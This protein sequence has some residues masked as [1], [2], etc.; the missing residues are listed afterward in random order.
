[1]PY[2]GS[3]N[4]IAEWIIENLPRAETFVDLF[5]GG[6]AVTHAALLS[7][8]YKNFIANDIDDRL[9]EFF[10]DCCF[11]KYTV[12][13]HSEWVTRAEFNAKKETDAYIALVWSFGNNGIDYLYGADIEEMKHAYHN[14]VYYGDVDGLRQFGINL[15]PSDN[16]DIY[17]R[18]LDY[19]RQIKTQKPNIQL[20]DLQRNL[21]I[22]R[23]Q[24]LQSL[25]SLHSDYQNVETP[26]GAL[27][28]CDPPYSGTNCGKYK[29][30]DS[31][32]FYE[33]AR[34]Q[35]N[36]YISEYDMPNDF[37]VVAE[38]EKTILSIA[39][40]N[41]R[42]ATERIYTNEITYNKLP[43]TEKAQ[44]RLNMARQMTLF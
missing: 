40:G 15:K 17:E 5:F 11:G 10:R 2:K 34:K 26:T 31:Q 4:G 12:E 23:L 35:E 24:S 22:E 44:I 16:E 38:I 32:R 3:K 29:G 43:E 42:K 41:S 1:M 18:Y 28:Y 27:I 9:V 36:I 33:W 39:D 30:F 7:G 13:N 25:Q 20:E 6:G 14:A 19:Q 21:E 37:I 8:K